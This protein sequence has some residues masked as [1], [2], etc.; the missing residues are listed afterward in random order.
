MIVTKVTASP[1]EDR[2]LYGMIS[3][4]W[5]GEHTAIL[6]QTWIVLVNGDGGRVRRLGIEHEIVRSLLIMKSTVHI[7][8]CDS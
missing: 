5:S 7:V 4:R 6:P 3:S 2:W 8:C 1:M